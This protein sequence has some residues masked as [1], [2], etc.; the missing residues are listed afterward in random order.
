[1]VIFMVLFMDLIDLVVLVLWGVGDMM[2]ILDIS[3][4]YRFKLGREIGL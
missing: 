2:C 4:N 1:M 3:L